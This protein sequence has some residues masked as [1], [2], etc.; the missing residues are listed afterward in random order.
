META[1][2]EIILPS[3][4]KISRLDACREVT[5]HLDK[6]PPIVWRL[7]RRTTDLPEDYQGGAGRHQR[8]AKRP[9]RQ[10]GQDQSSNGG[11]QPQPGN[12]ERGYYQPSSGSFRSRPTR[13]E[14]RSR[15]RRA[16][17]AGAPL[18]MVI[19]NPPV[20]QYDSKPI[21]PTSNSEQG[22]HYKGHKQQPIHETEPES[23][24]HKHRS[25]K[26]RESAPEKVAPERPVPTIREYYGKTPYTPTVP[27]PS[28]QP[29]PRFYESHD[30]NSFIPPVGLNT[31]AD[32]Q[33]PA[34][35]PGLSVVIGGSEVSS[36]PESYEGQHP[37]D[38][39]LE[40]ERGRDHQS[41]QRNR[42]QCGRDGT[43]EAG[44][45]TILPLRPAEPLPAQ[46]IESPIER[47]AHRP[48][49]RPF[50]QHEEEEIRKRPAERPAERSSRNKDKA[51]NHRRSHREVNESRMRRRE[52][53]RRRSLSRLLG[54]C[55]RTRDRDRSQGRKQRNR[56]SSGFFNFMRRPSRSG[57]G[58]QSTSSSSSRDRK[59]KNRDDRPCRQGRSRSRGR[60]RSR[61]KTRSIPRWS[62]HRRRTSDQEE[63]WVD[64]DRGDGHTSHRHQR[65]TLSKTQRSSSRCSRHQHTGRSR[66]RGQSASGDCHEGDRWSDSDS[67]SHFLPPK[68][69]DENAHFKALKKWNVERHRRK[70]QKRKEEQCVICAATKKGGFFEGLFNHTKDKLASKKPRDG[71]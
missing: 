13:R 17:R 26:R 3:I 20:H 23:R 69:V 65:R 30:E 6:Y 11:Q 52:R 12:N 39:D 41:M 2:Q 16:S 62:R 49:R 71:Q 44:R 63:E 61:S 68:E 38:L 51:K 24:G 18:P 42:Q 58:S 59:G 37:P 36:W 21:Q 22:H 47:P 46:S 29:Q 45:Q 19:E 67:Q 43:G 34:P 40:I 57:R 27:G 25:G 35:Q 28:S 4:G 1:G 55:S 64:I 53:N 10:N 60:G 56:R 54:S 70:E 8:P 7:E 9:E 48:A 5:D 33:V 50:P 15:E 32:R 66:S 31:Y 14:G